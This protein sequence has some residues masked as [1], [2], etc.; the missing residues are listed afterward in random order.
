MGAGFVS[1]TNP[2]VDDSPDKP[3]Q[4]SRWFESKL[5]GIKVSEASKLIMA[6]KSCFN[7]TGTNVLIVIWVGYKSELSINHTDFYHPENQTVTF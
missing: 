4:L 6:Q 2:V 1:Q 7:Q 3:K 5:L